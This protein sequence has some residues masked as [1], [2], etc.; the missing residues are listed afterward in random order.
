MKEI[1]RHIEWWDYT[2]IQYQYTGSNEG[3]ANIL[4]L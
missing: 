4:P 1:A 2:I 3:E